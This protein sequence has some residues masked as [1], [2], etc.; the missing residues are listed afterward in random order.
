MPV[1]PAALFRFALVATPA[2]ARPP[3]EVAAAIDREIDAR[4]ATANVPLSPFA[5]DAEFLR[6]ASLDLTG[7]LPTPR[8]P[9][10]SSTAPTR[11]SGRS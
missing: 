8:R 5:S 7:R 4:L 2:A 9:P 10:P 3:A 6:R 1:R 11:T